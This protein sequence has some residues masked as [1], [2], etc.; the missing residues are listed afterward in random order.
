M[1]RVMMGLESGFW[2]ELIDCYSCLQKA[3]K[4]KASNAEVFFRENYF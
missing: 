2:A 3:N 4:E 1:F